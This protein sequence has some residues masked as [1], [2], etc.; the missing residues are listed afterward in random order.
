VEFYFGGVRGRRGGGVADVLIR[1]K[2]KSSFIL[3]SSIII[4]K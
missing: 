4:S 2:T 3:I 1:V